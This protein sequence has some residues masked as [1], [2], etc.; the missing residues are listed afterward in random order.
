[1][2]TLDAALDQVGF[3]W[4]QSTIILATGLVWSGDA[5]ELGVMAFLVP[6]MKQ[7]W[8][9]SQA[10]ADML[11]SIVFVGML[12][13]APLWGMLSDSLGR[14]TTWLVTTAVTAVGG[15]ASAAVPDRSVSAFI[16]SRAL[17]GVGVSGTNLGFTL[18]SEFLP[19]RTRGRALVL[20][21]VFFSLGS[22]FEVLVAATVLPSCGWRLMLV[23]T[24]LP[25]L[26]A[27][28]LSPWVPESPRLDCVRN[29]PGRA[30][31]TLQRLAARNGR[32]PLD[33]DGLE[34]RSGDGDRLLAASRSSGGEW[35][36]RLAHQLRVLMHP[37]LRRTV[38]GLSLGWFCCT[39]SYFGIV[40][41]TPKVM[42][43]TPLASPPY[44]PSAPSTN[45]PPAAPPPLGCTAHFS[46]V[47]SLVI[48][49]AEV[50]GILASAAFIN[51][52]GRRW[53][54]LLT[55]GGCSVCLLL[56]SLVQLNQSS[57]AIGWAFARALALG[58]YSA[59]YVL[60]AEALPTEVRSSGFGLVSLSSRLAGTLTPYVA[61]SV[62]EQ[63]HS[64]ALLCYALSG[65]RTT[66]SHPAKLAPSHDTSPRRGP[67]PPLIP[68]L[69]F[70]LVEEGIYRG[71]YPSLVNLRF[72]Q[73][74]Q[75]RTVVS[76]LPEAPTPDLL[77]WCELHGIRNHAERIAVFKDE[78]TL[79]QERAAA[80]LQILILPERQPVYVHCL[81]GVSVTGTLLM[82]M[83]KLQRWVPA[84]Y[85]AEF[86]RF[87]GQ[88]SE[89]VSAPAAHISHFVESF[90]PDIVTAEMSRVP[91]WLDSLRAMAS[92]S[93]SAEQARTVRADGFG[94]STPLGVHSAPRT[95]P[96]DRLTSEEPFDRR[97]TDATALTAWARERVDSAPAAPQAFAQTSLHPPLSSSL[98]ALALEGLTMGPTMVLHEPGEV[99]RS[100][101]A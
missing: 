89:V 38:I 75:L 1:M 78:V 39:F 57:K 35:H 51:R 87:A 73:R 62:F 84:C 22:I 48:S 28:L 70:A 37:S 96:F 26:G 33:V 24:T 6:V 13:G 40:M 45:P 85:V 93:A 34:I 58:G 97:E 16:A 27:L 56:L 99:D 23:L 76:L 32:P 65:L 53:T 88:G 8:D 2:T 82:C 52:L 60:T 4:A 68:P 17:V 12:V 11:A 19:T 42:S 3:G 77:A 61:G 90:K 7:H 81:D 66:P 50:P 30:V 67:L 47:A 49:C 15:L 43:A 86:Q 63:S 46:Y 72:L 55:V 83:R 59:L 20:F 92:R 80:I 41:L 18:A 44:P 25:L 54:A 98:Q 95:L 21:E 9:M 64:V 94:G 14:R 71:A 69:R 79:T 31:S 29:N 10:Q 91:E 100:E 101:N 5:M 36:A 74:L